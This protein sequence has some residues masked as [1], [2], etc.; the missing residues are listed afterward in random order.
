MEVCKNDISYGRNIKLVNTEQCIRLSDSFT[1]LTAAQKV[2]LYFDSGYQWF[3]AATVSRRR[4]TYCS[5]IHG[6]ASVKKFLLNPITAHTL[7][8]FHNASLTGQFDEAHVRCLLSMQSITSHGQIANRFW[9][10][11]SE[12]HYSHNNRGERSLCGV[13]LTKLTRPFTAFD[14]GLAASHNGRHI[15][16]QMS[17]GKLKCQRFSQQHQGPARGIIDWFTFCLAPNI[18]PGGQKEGGKAKD[19]RASSAVGVC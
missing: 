4:D 17:S 9:Q 2:D 19:E 11:S 13:V 15:N 16:L 3:Q 1:C 7:V 10:D 12:K 18:H 6:K 5:R 14:T 8:M